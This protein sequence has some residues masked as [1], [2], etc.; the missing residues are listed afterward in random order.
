MKEVLSTKDLEEAME[1]EA[2]LDDMDDAEDELRKSMEARGKQ[3]NLSFF[4]FT[5]TP[6]AKTLEVFGVRGIDG[7]PVA[8][9]LYSMKQA[10]EEGFIMDV[11]KSYTTYKSFFKL[12]KA[13]EEDPD[14]NKKKAVRAIA[15]FVSLH[16]HNLAQKSEIIIEHFRQVTMKK[17]GGNAKAMVVTS[18]RLHVVRYKHAFDKYIK[19]KG[20]TDIKNSGCFFRH[21]C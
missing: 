6:K 5:A 18:S 7:K 2:Q 4:A 20:Y 3:N 1:E 14:I 10:I 21:C 16:P 11:L 13:I 17:I 8:F 19:E 15:R 12:S 9:H